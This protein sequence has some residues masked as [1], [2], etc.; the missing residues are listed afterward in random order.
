MFTYNTYKI[1]NIFQKERKCTH[2]YI[3]EVS[4]VLLYSLKVLY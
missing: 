1:R 2:L 3:A 4:S